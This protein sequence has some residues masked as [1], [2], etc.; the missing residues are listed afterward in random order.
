VA[1]YDRILD[2]T[3][4]NHEGCGATCRTLLNLLLLGV[5]E[6]HQD[7]QFLQI[8]SLNEEKLVLTNWVNNQNPY[9]G[10]AGCVIGHQATS[11][12]AVEAICVVVEANSA[13]NLE[14]AKKLVAIYMGMFTI[15]R[16]LSTLTKGFLI[17]Y[18]RIDPPTAL[19]SK[20]IRHKCL[21]SLLGR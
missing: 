12:S 5:L 18:Y 11:N 20:E 4:W 1:V 19:P 9:I 16:S 6:S 15:G 14:G 21:W 2:A 13:E 3:Y 10:V 17:S 8:V 7:S